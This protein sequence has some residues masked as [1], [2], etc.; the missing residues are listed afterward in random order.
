MPNNGTDSF[1]SSFQSEL[2]VELE[3]NATY[4]LYILQYPRFINLLHS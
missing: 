1:K 3:L 4:V 2:E